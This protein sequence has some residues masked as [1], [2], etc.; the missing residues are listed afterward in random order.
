VGECGNDHADADLVDAWTYNEDEGEAATNAAALIDPAT[1]EILATVPLPVDAGPPIVMENAVF[2]PGHESSTAVIVD[3]AAWTITAT[4]DLS[5][6]TRCS[7][8]GYD[9]ASIYMATDDSDQ[10]DMLVV[11]ATYGVLQRFDIA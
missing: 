9:G 3:R 7:L 8:C 11:D 10:L 1:N 4:P 5:R 6:P 2:L